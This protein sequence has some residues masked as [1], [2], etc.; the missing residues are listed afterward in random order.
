MVVV[1]SLPLKVS[2]KPAEPVAG[3]AAVV[4]V[5]DR[6]RRAEHRRRGHR[7]GED[8]LLDEDVAARAG[9]GEQRI[10]RT[11]VDGRAQPRLPDLPDQD[12]AIEQAKL[13]LADLGVGQLAGEVVDLPRDGE[14]GRGQDPHP[15]TG[16]RFD[17][18]PAVGEHPRI[19]DGQ[20]PELRMLPA[21]PGEALLH[22]GHQLLGALGPAEGMPG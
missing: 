15:G 17:V 8:R 20:S 19:G 22:L 21:G 11:G 12:V 2:G 10:D 13:L 7:G 5:V 9:H 3:G 4:G 6:I 14:A 1:P 16:V 18:V